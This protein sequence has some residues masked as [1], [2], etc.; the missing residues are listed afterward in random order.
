MF[1][2]PRLHEKFGPE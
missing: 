2:S 1:I